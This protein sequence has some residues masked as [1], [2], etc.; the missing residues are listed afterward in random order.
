MERCERCL[1]TEKE[2]RLFD[3]ISRAGLLKMCANCAKLEGFPI[4]RMP[5]DADDFVASREPRMPR[6][7]QNLI[8]HFNWN[9]RM[10]RRR[11]KLSTKQFAQKINEKEELIL[12]LEAGQIP[13]VSSQEEFDRII[14]KIEKALDLKIKKEEEFVGAEIE[15]V[16]DIFNDKV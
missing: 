5:S 10:A 3:V 15:L 8:D 12:K 11:T 13:I 1:K 16:D 2:A 14:G 4:A 7:G 9:L 6:I